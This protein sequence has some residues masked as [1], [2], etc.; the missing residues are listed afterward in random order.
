MMTT[1]EKETYIKY[2]GE[3]MKKFQE[4]A[5]KVKA[6]ASRRTWIDAILK[7]VVIDRKSADAKAIK[8]M[9]KDKAYHYLVMSCTGKAF[10][11]VQAEE[12]AE[13]FGDARK[14]WVEL[15]KRYSDLSESDLITLTTEFNACKM[16]KLMDDPT[17]W[18]AELEHIQAKMVRASTQ[19]KSDPE[20]V[21][22][23]MMQIP[24][25]YDMATQA[26]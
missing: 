15:S 20:M 10:D 11:Y 6:I 17:L 1:E 16:K 9:K 21:A 4:W 24:K 23:I 22:A 13:G 26:I 3:D 2:D 7:D 18:Y 8:L 25:E 19:K 12:D 5:M 14:A